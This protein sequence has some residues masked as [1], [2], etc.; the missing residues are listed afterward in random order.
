[1]AVSTPQRK[2]YNLAPLSRAVLEDKGC[3]LQPDSCYSVCSGLEKQEGQLCCGQACRESDLWHSLPG[4]N[5]KPANSM[6]TTG[7]WSPLL[8]RADRRGAKL[9]NSNNERVEFA[10]NCTDLL[11]FFTRTSSS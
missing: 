7:M 10:A 3:M 1:M 5:D 9:D 8:P 2:S 4:K 6:N 11:T